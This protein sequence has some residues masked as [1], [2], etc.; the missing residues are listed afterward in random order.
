M[1]NIEK[2]KDEIL[3]KMETYSVAD[4]VKISLKDDP[5]KF[6]IMPQKF[7]NESLKRIKNMEI[8]EDDVWVVT[9][10]KCGTTWTQE[11]VWMIGHNLDYKSS[12]NTRLDDRFPFLEYVS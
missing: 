6:C 8:F 1:F 2:P 5:K 12:F 10:P 9:Y 3:T 11:M 4:L 7:V